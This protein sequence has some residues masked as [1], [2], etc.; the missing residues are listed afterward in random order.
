[1]I[2]YLTML[3]LM[4]SATIVARDRRRAET[5]LLVLSTVTT[6]MSAEVL[7]V[8]LDMFAGMIPSAGSAAAPFVAMSALAAIA[9]GA[10]IIMVFER[11]LSRSDSADTFS[12][13]LRI[14]LALGLCGLAVALAAIKS[15]AP[16]GVQAATA[17]GSVAMLFVVIVRRL[18][19][20]S[21]LAVVLFVTLAG[22]AAAIIVPRLHPVSGAIEGFAASSTAESLALAKRAIADTP[23]L[24]NGVGTYRLLVPTYQDFGSAPALGP[25]ST[26]ISIAIEWGKP[27][28]FILA[29]FAIQLF[30]FVFRGA[31]RRGRDAFFASA[32]AGAVLVTLGEA[33]CDSSL[34][35]TTV[36]IVVAVMVGL[37][38]SQSVGRASGIK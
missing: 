9:N 38:L 10:I 32:A 19:F 37:G 11:F 28:L 22:I 30:V 25:P 35:N 18:A 13:P 1:M 21:W 24:G 20:R 36:Q 15:L 17:I 34:L 3:A 16:G 27:A 14:R 23:W 5:L 31:V 26:A 33:F 7:A 8:R 12:T 29:A 6:F 2:L 4:V